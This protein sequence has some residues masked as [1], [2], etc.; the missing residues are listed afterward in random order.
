ML[1]VAALITEV[2]KLPERILAHGSHATCWYVMVYYVGKNQG[3]GNTLPK[4]AKLYPLG[5]SPARWTDV[6]N[7]A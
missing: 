1:V 7:Q 5:V 2:H 6:Q 4:F 3:P